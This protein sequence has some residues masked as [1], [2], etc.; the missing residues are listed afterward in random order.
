MRPWSTSEFQ[1]DY[2]TI[3]FDRLIE[4]GRHMNEIPHAENLSRRRNGGAPSAP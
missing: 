1:S 3:E 2:I 4:V